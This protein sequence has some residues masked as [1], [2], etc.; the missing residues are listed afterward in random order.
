[1]RAAHPCPAG[2]G[3]AAR[4]RVTGRGEAVEPALRAFRTG[5]HIGGDVDQPADVRVAI[6]RMT[7]TRRSMSASV[8]RQFTMAG[9]RAVMPR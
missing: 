2:E 8:V 5:A 4:T 3:W 1:M 7:E 9:R 6:S